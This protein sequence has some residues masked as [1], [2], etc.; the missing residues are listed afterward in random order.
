MNFC[1]ECENY[2]N[3]QVKTNN[4]NHNELNYVCR[5][6][7]YEEK[8]NAKK[9]NQKDTQRFIY[10][11]HYDINSVFGSEYNTDYLEH[12]HTLPRAN[13][14]TCPN[15][16]CPSNQQVISG[17]ETKNINEVVYIV[18]NKKL[19]TFQYKCCNCST[20]WKNK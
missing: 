3:L 2:L 20:M 6:C 19:M 7:Q 5:N 4:N 15:S 14:I 9:H 16:E 18:I 12:D 1:E 11:N 8:Y 10:K 17:K 13:N